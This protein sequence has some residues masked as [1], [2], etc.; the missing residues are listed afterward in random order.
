MLYSV[1]PECISRM[2]GYFASIC[3]TLSVSRRPQEMQDSTDATLSREMVE[4]DGSSMTVRRKTGSLNYLSRK[5]PTKSKKG[6]SAYKNFYAGKKQETKHG[7]FLV[8]KGRRTKK[9]ILKPL[10]PKSFQK[11]APGGGESKAEVV[12][13]VGKHVQSKT[14][15]ACT[16][17]GKGLLAGLADKKIPVAPARHSIDELTPTHTFT[18]SRMTG[19]QRRMLKSCAS[20]KAKPS[21]L[22]TPGGTKVK[23]VAGDNEAE[24]EFSRIK[25]SLRRS[26]QFGRTSPKYAHIL[27]LA[28]KRLSDNGGL[29]T[30]LQSVATYRN[31]R[32]NHLG[33][34]P[35]MWCDVA[36]DKDWILK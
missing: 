17:A 22:V 28:H 29:N 23:V 13:H 24:A 15:V 21:A 20:Q 18:L 7:R 36:V 4:V 31:A 19:G 9:S 3:K 8:L 27:P 35:S 10:E 11:G 26:N 30:V 16:D 14:V 6:S 33:W 12:R 5:K 25:R 1:W 34:K 32:F 2:Q